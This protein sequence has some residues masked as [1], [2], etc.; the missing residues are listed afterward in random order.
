M[1][2]GIVELEIRQRKNG[3]HQ[4]NNDEIKD[5]SSSG[6]GSGIDLDDING[7]EMSPFIRQNMDTTDEPCK[8]FN[9]HC[10]CFYPCYQVKRSL[11]YYH[12]THLGIGLFNLLAVTCF[13]YVF[14]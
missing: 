12:S 5:Y 11:W 9:T 4:N 13:F 3:S 10:K 1:M 2:S 8:W 6:I 7:A 14:V